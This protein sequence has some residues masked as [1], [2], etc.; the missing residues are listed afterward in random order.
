MS[1]K[2]F[3]NPIT[4]QL[5]NGKTQLTCCLQSLH[6]RDL[7]YDLALQKSKSIAAEKRPS[8]CSSIRRDASHQALQPKSNYLPFPDEIESRNVPINQISTHHNQSEIMIRSPEMIV[9]NNNC[10]RTIL[11]PRFQL[12]GASDTILLPNRKKRC[13]QLLQRIPSSI[14][15]YNKKH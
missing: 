3:D 2:E 9:I 1:S 7:E 11:Y 12:S 15:R 10:L 6:S 8:R 13:L 5:R 4:L 14:L